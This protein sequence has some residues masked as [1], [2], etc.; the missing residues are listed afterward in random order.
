MEQVMTMNFAGKT[1]KEFIFVSVKEPDAEEKMQY[2]VELVIE[3][4]ILKS[5]IF[6]RTFINF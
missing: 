2:F 6:A 5:R 3:Y 1:L 4:A